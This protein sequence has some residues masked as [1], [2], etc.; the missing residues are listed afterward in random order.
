[1]VFAFAMRMAGMMDKAMLALTFTATA[2]AWWDTLRGS[3]VEHREISV[4][5][6]ELHNG[7]RLAADA[8]V[9]IHVYAYRNTAS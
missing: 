8:L 9:P 1:M 3:V 7:A 2:F 5:V 6:Q 4:V